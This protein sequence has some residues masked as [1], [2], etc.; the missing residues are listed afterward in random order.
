MLRY[1][2]SLPVEHVA[3]VLR[4]GL[5]VALLAIQRRLHALPLGMKGRRKEERGGEGKGEEGRGGKWER[6]E[7]RGEGKRSKRKG[8]G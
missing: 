1:V 2:H 4:E 7:G 5:H 6:E 3:E 8:S